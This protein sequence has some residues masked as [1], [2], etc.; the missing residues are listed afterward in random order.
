MIKVLKIKTVLKLEGLAVFLTCLYFYSKLDASWLLFV[1]LWLLP[2]VS[3]IGYFKNLKLGAFLYN[4]I[5]N[6]ILAL[7]II[8]IGLW[9]GDNFTIS[10]GV[11]LASHI[12]LDRFF[13]YGL[14][15]IDN[16]KHTHIQKL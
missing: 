8:V 3:M 10:L 15:Y 16:F 4:L 12:G 11:I 7:L 1:L 2:D 13:G 9:Q 5:H 6:Y 14:K